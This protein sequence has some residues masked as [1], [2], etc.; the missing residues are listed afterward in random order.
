M[1]VRWTL[2]PHDL[3]KVAT[4]VVTHSLFTRLV[5][6]HQLLGGLAANGT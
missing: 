1:I 6:T 5:P 2:N 3:G 4:L